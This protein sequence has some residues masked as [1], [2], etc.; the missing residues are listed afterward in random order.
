VPTQQAHWALL[1]LVVTVALHAAPPSAAW[2]SRLASWPPLV[3]GLVYAALVI[4][5]FLHAPPSTRFIY[6]QF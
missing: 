3:Q 5:V 6:F 1:L 2:R 4:A